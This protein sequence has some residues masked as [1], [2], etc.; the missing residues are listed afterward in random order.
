M[1]PAELARDRKDV[2]HIPRA[3]T[4]LA[5]FGAAS[6]DADTAQRPTAAPTRK[7]RKRPN[8]PDNDQRDPSGPGRSDVEA[9][10]YWDAE[11]LVL[12]GD[13]RGQRVSFRRRG[14]DGVAWP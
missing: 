14:G 7:S 8:T 6:R 5:D 10:G 1:T 4:R 9:A 12:A 13:H 2:A 11:T 3:A